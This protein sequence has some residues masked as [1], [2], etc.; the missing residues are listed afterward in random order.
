MKKIIFVTAVSILLGLGIWKGYQ[1]PTSVLGEQT[2]PRVTLT[3]VDE[4]LV[5]TYSGIFATTPFDAL[6][7]VATD[8]QI[9]LKIKQYDFGMFVEEI[10]DRS[11]FTD[12]AWLYSINGVSGDVAADKKILKTGD[13]VEWHYMKPTY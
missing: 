2:I 13:L 11:N 1:K 6:Q 9:F 10:G 4:D 12:Y 8:N 3:L 5:S 7:K